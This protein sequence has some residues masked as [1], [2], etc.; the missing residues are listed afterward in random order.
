MRVVNFTEAR[1]SLKAIL[2]GVINDCDHTIISRNGSEDAVLM[3]M[4]EYSSIMETLHLMRSPAN[5]DHLQ[6]SIAQHRGG[7][8]RKQDRDSQSE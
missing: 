3:S 2:D 4:T 7:Q 1:K 8:V 6:K 5:V